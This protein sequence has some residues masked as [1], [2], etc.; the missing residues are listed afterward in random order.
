MERIVQENAD[1]KTLGVRLYGAMDIRLEEMRTFVFK[2]GKNEH[3][4]LDT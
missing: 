3:I 1:R 4:H 2:R